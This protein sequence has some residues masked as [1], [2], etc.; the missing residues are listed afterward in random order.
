MKKFAVID[1][2]AHDWFET[3]FDTEAEA[4]NEADYLWGAMTDY[5]KKRRESFFVA[6][7]D[8]D[9]DGC[10]DWDTI[11]EIKVYK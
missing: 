9:E 6:S 7:C 10:I 3:I 2:T 11:K 4:I 1:Q 5:D 8:L